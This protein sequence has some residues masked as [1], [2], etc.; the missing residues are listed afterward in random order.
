[1]KTKRVERLFPPLVVYS[2]FEYRSRFRYSNCYNLNCQVN[3]A[4]QRVTNDILSLDI[5]VATQ[6]HIKKG[7]LWKQ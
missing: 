3:L 6:N 2:K 5:D 1:M 7:V 4:T